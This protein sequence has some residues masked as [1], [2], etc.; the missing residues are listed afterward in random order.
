MWWR[1]WWLATNP[2][3]QNLPKNSDCLGPTR[4]FWIPL[5]RPQ[6]FCVFYLHFRPK[7]P[8]IRENSPNSWKFNKNSTKKAQKQQK[9]AK[10][11]KNGAETL[12]LPLSTSKFDIIAFWASFAPIPRFFPVLFWQNFRF[13]GKVFGCLPAVSPVLPRFFPGSSP[14]FSEFSRFSRIFPIFSRFFQNFPNFPKFFRIFLYLPNFQV[15]EAQS[16]I[17]MR[18]SQVFLVI[19]RLLEFWSVCFCLF[20]IFSLLERFSPAHAR[21]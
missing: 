2:K 5:T 21:P 17:L 12:K 10:T 1:N 9:R 7:F 6:L 11:P 3:G 16:S 13:L 4:Q 14:N 15:F 8:E 18:N 19:L 20:T